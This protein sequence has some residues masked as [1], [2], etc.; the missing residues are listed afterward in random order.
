MNIYHYTTHKEKTNLYLI[1]ELGLFVM[2][3]GSDDLTF[4]N[5]NKIFY[6]FYGKNKQKSEHIFNLVY[7][8]VHLTKYSSG[9]LRHIKV[10]RK[11]NGKYN[12]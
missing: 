1:D 4:L 11:Y 3:S 5:E 9:D 8:M 7:Y 6:Y 10:Y 12:P 2:Y